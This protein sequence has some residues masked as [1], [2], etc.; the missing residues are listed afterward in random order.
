MYRASDAG[1][2]I[3]FLAGAMT[4]A[5]FV[6]K[7]CSSPQTAELNAD[8]RAETLMKWVHV[9]LVESVVFVGIAMVIDRKYAVAYAAGGGLELVVTYFE[10]AH[11]KQCGLANAHKPGT[12]DW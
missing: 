3:A 4:T 8:K 2:G 11:A 1:I 12:E 6:A 7:C 5:E 10:Y 9:G